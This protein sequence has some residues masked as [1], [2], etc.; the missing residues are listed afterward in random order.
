[1]GAPEPPSPP[2]MVAPEPPATI[3]PEP[4]AIPEPAAPA[5]VVGLTDYARIEVA[6]ERGETSRILA[7][8]KLDPAEL[9]RVRAEWAERIKTQPA[10]ESELEE[11]M[12]AARWE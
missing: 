10:L 2:A 11:A 5:R 7:R 1:M 9:D 8:L 3:P 4:P 6:F 12:E